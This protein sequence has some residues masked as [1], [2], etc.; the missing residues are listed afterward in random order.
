VE[1]PAA[2]FKMDTTVGGRHWQTPN[3][4]SADWGV[5]AVSPGRSRCWNKWCRDVR[6]SAMPTYQRGSGSISKASSRAWCCPR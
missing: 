5:A 3:P 1:K 2:A 6:N 4:M